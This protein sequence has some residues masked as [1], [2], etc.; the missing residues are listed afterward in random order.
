MKIED[1]LKLNYFK[2][3]HKQLPS[4]LLNWQ[5]IPSINN[6]LYTIIMLHM[7]TKLINTIY[8]NVH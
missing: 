4:Y 5:I 8:V 3:I 7:S 2:Y 1:M 6:L